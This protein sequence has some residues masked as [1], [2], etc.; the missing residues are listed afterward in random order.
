M[1]R[2]GGPQPSDEVLSTYRKAWQ[3]DR[4]ALVRNNLLSPWKEIYDNLVKEMGEPNSLDRPFQVQARFESGSPKCEE[5][6][7]G[8]SVNEIA[9]FLKNWIS[10][11]DFFG[12]SKEGMGATLSDVIAEEP[13]RFA[14]NAMMFKEL[15]IIYV[16][17]FFWGLKKSIE[18]SNRFNWPEVLNLS[19]LV[20][21]RT[22]YNKALDYNCSDLCLGY[23]LRNIIELL[24]TGFDAEHGRVPFDLRTRVWPILEIL[25]NDPD[26]TPGSEK[27]E[28]EGDSEL[29]LF[30]VSSIRGQ[31]LIAIIHYA[32]WVRNCTENSPEALKFSNQG[33][34]LMSE[35]REILDAHLDL[36]FD[37]SLA[38]RAIYGMEFPHL[39]FLDSIWASE[40][41]NKIFPTEESKIHL[42]NA[43]WRSYLQTN[44]AN[45]DVIKILEKQYSIAIDRLELLS[46]DL[47]LNADPDRHPE[48]KIAEHIMYLYWLGKLNPDDSNGLFSKF[49][50]KAPGNLRGYALNHIGFNLNRGDDPITPDV[51]D[52]LKHLWE[53]RIASIKMH[54]AESNELREFGWWFASG[55]FDENWSMKQLID[56]LG[57]VGE[58]ELDFGVLKKLTIFASQN[59]GDAI[60]CLELIIR[61]KQNKWQIHTWRN[62]IKS[63]I[64]TVLKCGDPSAAK[65]ATSL[66]NYLSSLGYLE[67]KDL[68][69]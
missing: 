37:P 22:V 33:F 59:P 4:L 60:Q 63:I 16:R 14:V 18:K 64:G 2:F 57:L 36:N 15:D 27:E 12:S 55:K 26:P 47:E 5:E 56:V 49:W 1:E 6:F 10:S 8:M 50:S 35:V 39:Q 42:W 24:T 20:I 17:A 69:K 28:M 3:R 25:S 51:L 44:E 53:A 7:K 41:V 62:E 45:S 40:N 52:R 67:Y 23:L 48:C 31:A 65:S 21:E 66:T 29:S 46:R 11:N 34:D 32:L 13:D 9:D 68:L 30:G 38:I 61:G 58:I 19:Q 43:A 54:N